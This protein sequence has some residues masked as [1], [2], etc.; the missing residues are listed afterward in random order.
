MSTYL[1]ALACVVGL[2]IGQMLFKLSA[3]LVGES[4]S[5]LSLKVLSTLTAAI[6]VYAVTTIAWVWV[7]RRMDLGK[8]YP[9]MAL[10]F[11]LVPIGSHF[12]FGERFSPSY[13]A[14]VALIV[15]G[16]VVAVRS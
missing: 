2:S 7:L 12:A 13:F 3:E 11:I 1:A 5:W 16:I 8:A 10:A 15:I 9:L 4:N 14:G 6:F